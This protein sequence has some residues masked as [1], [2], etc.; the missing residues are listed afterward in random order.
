MKKRME[1]KIFSQSTNWKHGSFFWSP[2]LGITVTGRHSEGSVLSVLNVLTAYGLEM[3][4][5]NIPFR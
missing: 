1:G 5:S 4:M 3:K 2:L